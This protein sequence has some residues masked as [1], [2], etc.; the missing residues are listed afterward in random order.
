VDILERFSELKNQRRTGRGSA[1]WNKKLIRYARALVTIGHERV[2]FPEF[3]TLPNLLEI[4]RDLK[5]SMFGRRID[6]EHLLELLSPYFLE[7]R[8]GNQ[9]IG[10]S[11]YVVLPAYERLSKKLTLKELYETKREVKA[12]QKSIEKVYNLP[13]SAEALE[14]AFSKASRFDRWDISTLLGSLSYTEDES[15]RLH[16]DPQRIRREIRNVLFKNWTDVDINTSAPTLLTLLYRQFTDSVKDIEV[17]E[18]Y[19]DNKEARRTEFASRFD[20]SYSSAKEIL[21]QIFIGRVPTLGQLQVL[22]PIEFYLQRV[23]GRTKA[24]LIRNDEWYSRLVSDVSMITDEVYLYHKSLSPKNER[25]ITNSFGKAL[26]L[27]RWKK[28]RVIYHL[29][30]GLEREILEVLRNEIASTN[31]LLIHDGF[32]SEQ[33]QNIFQLENLITKETGYNVKLDEKIL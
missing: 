8:Q 31:H 6:S 27:E 12:P 29:Y 9:F 1:T 25:I 30:V 17:I 33:P 4:P 11:Q 24:K 7:T 21:T 20:L 16:T 13:M 28:S 3:K 14:F 15:G 19:I 5:R 10:R 32:I 22:L 23:V 18:D 2:Y 26:E